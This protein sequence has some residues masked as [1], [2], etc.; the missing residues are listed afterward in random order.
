M[1]LRILLRPYCDL[2]LCPWNSVVNKTCNI[3]VLR[4]SILF[5]SPVPKAQGKPPDSPFLILKIDSNINEP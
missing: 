4:T 2:F 3:S 5:F 1:L